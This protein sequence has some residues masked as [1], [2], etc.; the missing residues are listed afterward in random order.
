MT[1]DNTATVPVPL[2]DAWLDGLASLIADAPINLVSRGDRTN[3]RALHVDECVAVAQQI[4]PGRGTWW[5]DLGTGGGLPGLVLAASFPAVH[6]TLLDARAKKLVLVRGF[7]EE[8]GLENVTTV[9]GRAEE[10]ASDRAHRGRYAGVVSR[11]VGSLAPT[12]ALCRGFVD[13]GEIVAVRGPRA[14]AEAESL[15]RWCD[16]LGVTLPT[17]ELI[18]GTMRPTWL[19]RLRGRG[20]APG[21][22][23]RARTRLLQS[24]RGGTR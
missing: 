3:V 18:S 8:L 4:R 20:P 24:A 21:R 14:S 10:L 15:V 1:G 5:M 12:V 9:H 16:D 19:V 13:D 6:W 7:A 2:S 17:V 11:A 23:P 22:F